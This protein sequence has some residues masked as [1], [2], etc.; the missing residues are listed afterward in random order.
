MSRATASASEP[1]T[2]SSPIS[3]NAMK[4]SGR[5]ATG[6]LAAALALH[7]QQPQAP[8]RPEGDASA[9]RFKSGVELINVTAT[10]SD[11][12]GRFV[13][14]LRQE[15]FLLYEEDQPQAVTHFSSERGPVSL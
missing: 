4:A 14:G 10:V 8:V 9:F 11:V 15:D 6:L 5:Q 1:T 7:G 2:G 12:N 13:P 3:T